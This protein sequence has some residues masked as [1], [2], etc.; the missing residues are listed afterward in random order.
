M[1]T[2]NLFMLAIVLVGGYFLVKSWTTS[3]QQTGW[4]VN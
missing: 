4:V 2:D 3:P 1:K